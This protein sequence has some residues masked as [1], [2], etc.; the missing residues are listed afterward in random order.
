[1]LLYPLTQRCLHLPLRMTA[2]GGDRSLPLIYLTVLLHPLTQRGMHLL[3]AGGGVH[4]LPLIYLALLLQ[5]LTQ[6]YL[7]LPLRMMA[8]V[9]N[10]MGN[11]PHGHTSLHVSFQMEDERI[12]DPPLLSHTT[13]AVPLLTET[14]QKWNLPALSHT[15]SLTVQLLVEVNQ[16]WN[17]PLLSQSSV[18]LLTEDNRMIKFLPVHL[19]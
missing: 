17:L 1:M 13:P 5:P 10:V 19:V 2:G 12:W 4:S 3:T 15:T 18:S 16:Q 8:G 11:Q 14:N 7:N 6:R 9:G